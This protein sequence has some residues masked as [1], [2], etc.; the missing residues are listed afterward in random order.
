M[1]NYTGSTGFGEKFARDIRLDPFA[2]PASEINE[3]ADE[4]IRR[5]RFIDGSRQVAGGRQLRRPSGELAA[6]D[7]DALQALISHAGLINR[8]AQWGTSDTIYHRELMTGGPPW[9]QARTGAS[10]IRFAA[11][12]VSRRRSSCR[13]ANGLPRAAEQ[14]ARELE[15]PAAHERAQ[16]PAC[17]AGRESLDPER[18]NGR[19]FYEEVHAWLA[20]WLPAAH[21]G[22][23][24]RRKHDVFTSVRSLASSSA[25]AVWSRILARIY[26]ADQSPT[27]MSD[28]AQ[29]FLSSLS[30][31]Q[32][33]AVSFTFDNLKERER[34]GYVPTEDH[35][36]AGLPLELMT[37]RQRAAVHDLLKS[38]LSEKDDPTTDAIMQLEA[39]LNLIENPPGT[40]PGS[41][42]R[43][44]L[45]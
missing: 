21:G 42:E 35:P 20:R 32:R 8:E 45:K 10:R 22:P 30:P 24:T 13:S 33:K 34:F 7:D 1:T 31:E 36:R 41:P 23:V 6:G 11:R 3:A 2:G 4:A 29:V 27:D 39:V 12:P 28:A 37:G 15:R 26:A 9:E 17:M 16:P 19:H 18:R 25:P 44:P 40:K 43:N 5:F 38:G 14:H